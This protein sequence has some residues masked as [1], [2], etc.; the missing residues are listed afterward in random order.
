M[1]LCVIAIGDPHFQLTNIPEVN[2]FIDKMV[3]L[4]EEKSPNFIV[5]L[6]DVLHN[7]EKLHTTPLNKAYEF[8]ERLNKI[9]KVFV[10][11]GNHDYENN[12]QFLS[13]NH[14]MNAMKKWENTVIVD[15]TILY[16]I[17]GFKFLFV[18][19]VFPGR[20]FEAIDSLHLDNWEKSI[21]CIFA[22]QEFL[23]CQMGMVK[24]IIGD[25]YPIDYPYVVSGHIHS[26]QT[27]QE[28]IY[29]PG[30]SLEH[31][32]GESI[33][34]VIPCFIFEEPLKK[35][36]LEEIDLNLPKK[37]IVYVDV[38]DLNSLDLENEKNNKDDKLKIKISG[39]YEQFKLLKKSQKYKKLLENG[40]KVEFKP[41]RVETKLKNEAISNSIK[42][43]EGNDNFKKILK[44]LIDQEK[45]PYLL[46]TYELI[47]N[48]KQINIDDILYL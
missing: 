33:K 34:N 36:K 28:N 3:L 13:Q 25:S 35:Y 1:N 20:F 17:N 40:V 44:D 18:P 16:E 29:Y 43:Y 46:K 41:K 4:C 47:I 45:N 39:D 31:S 38:D 12:Q 15:K 7:H 24:S 10:L 23:N 6:G 22:H 8:I 37:K 5:I 19:Y 2:L 27:I 32:Y 30:S 48:N 9:A 26:N 14:W 11:V 21:T 42:Q